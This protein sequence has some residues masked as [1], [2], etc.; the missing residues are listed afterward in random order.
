MFLFVNS[1]EL[2]T[3]CIFVVAQIFILYIYSQLQALEVCKIWYFHKIIFVQAS[4]F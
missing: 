3:E 2:D 4:Y 1:Y